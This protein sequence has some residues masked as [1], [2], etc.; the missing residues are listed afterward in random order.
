ML[1]LLRSIFIF[2]GKCKLGI[3][4]ETGTCPLIFWQPVNVFT[5]FREIRLRSRTCNLVTVPYMINAHSEFL[6]KFLPRA[7]KSNSILILLVSE[8]WFTLSILCELN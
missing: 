7:R 4:S 1:F 8:S 2:I 6:Q 3:Y 5:F